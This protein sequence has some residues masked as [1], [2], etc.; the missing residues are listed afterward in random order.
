MTY[1][2]PIKVGDRVAL[3]PHLDLWM[4]GVRFGQVIESVPN[5]E[6]GTMYLIE[7]GIG[8]DWIMGEDLLGAVRTSQPVVEAQAEALCNMQ[9][10]D[11][12]DDAAFRA[13]CNTVEA[14]IRESL[15]MELERGGVLVSIEDNM[16]PEDYER[17]GSDMTDAA[18]EAERDLWEKF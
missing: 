7:H 6:G 2:T 14:Q 13:A 12:N 10:E 5:E 18:C 15:P 9:G 16:T 4:Q 11:P 3:A 8:T 1:H 17:M